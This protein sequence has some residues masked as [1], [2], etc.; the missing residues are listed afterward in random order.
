M[1]KIKHLAIVAM[2]PEELA[3]FY[4]EVFEMKII[5]RS[6]TGG[7]FMSDGYFN[8]ALLPNRIEGK[9][10]GL[11]HF[12]FEVEDSAEIAKRLK[13][14]KGLGPTARPDNRYYAESRATDP[15]G[16]AFDISEHGF[17]RMELG[18]ERKAHK[19]AKV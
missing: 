6:P 18:S 15:E 7:V 3:K 16:N 19:T 1:A 10:N 12:G 4:C 8:V 2:N 11:N 17:Q 14:Y 9:N 13:K 5:D